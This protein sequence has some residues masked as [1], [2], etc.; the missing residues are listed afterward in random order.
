MRL[1]TFVLAASAALAL[2]APAAAKE[3]AK[4]ELCGPAGCVAVTDKNDLR[5]IPTGETL[6]TR[7]PMS[8]YYA[9]ALSAKDDVTTYTWQI[10]Y[11]PGSNM[12][13]VQ[14]ERGGMNWHPIQGAAIGAMKRLAAQIEPFAAPA[15]TSVAIGD[16]V[17]REDA[18]SYLRL[19]E[20]TGTPPAHNLSPADWVAIDFRSERPSPWTDSGRELMYSPSTNVLERRVDRLVLPRWLAADIE[21][22]RPLAGSEGIRWL[23]WLAPAGLMAALLL[24]AGLGALLR[25]RF[26]AAPVPEPAP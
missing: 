4:A 26:G 15:I 12:L 24:V 14:D 3:L 7:P 17:V 13:A 11:I 2:A 16:R 1:A 22:A 18:S 8:S 9:L 6:G 23:P 25:A 10:Y 21:A 5:Q 19:L 20:E